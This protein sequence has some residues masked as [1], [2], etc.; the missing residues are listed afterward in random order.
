MLH[1]IARRIFNLAYHTLIPAS[2]WF[3]KLDGYNGVW[4]NTCFRIID[5]TYT[6]T[7]WAGDADER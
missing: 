6:L 2:F 3:D 1:Y 5:A 4:A 7:V